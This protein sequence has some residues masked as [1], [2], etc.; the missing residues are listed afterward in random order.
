MSNSIE[1]PRVKPRLVT[2]AHPQPKAPSSTQQI[3]V[4][5]SRDI[6]SYGTSFNEV[7]REGEGRLVT[8][9]YL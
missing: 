5:V 6:P 7:A 2:G 9:S 1:F 3:Y 4:R 8:G